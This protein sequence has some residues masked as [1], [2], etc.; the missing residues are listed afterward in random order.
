MRTAALLDLVLTLVVLVGCARPRPAAPPAATALPPDLSDLAKQ[1]PAAAPGGPRSENAGPPAPLSA[2]GE[3]V[4]PLRS[5]VAP[6][7]PGRVATV[8]VREGD[9]VKAGQPLAAFET[10]YLRLDLRRAEAELAR[11]EAVAGDAARD[12]ERKRQLVAGQSI[13]RAA[14]DHVQAA[15]DAAVAARAAAEAVVATVRQRIEDAT[16]RAPFEGVVEAKA[17]EAG[18]HVADG[19]CA[20][21]LVATARLRLRF[22]LPEQYLGRLREG[23]RVTATTDAAGSFTGRISMIG[24][25]VDPATR[26]L[27][28]EAD[29]D[30]AGG[31][32]KPGL[33]ARVAIAL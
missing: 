3:L 25:V 32:L 11:A 22:R 13:S 17:I 5:R 33:F 21:V 16:L 4:S 18:E 19:Q 26:T 24:G 31:R 27:V 23:Q 6:K 10:D 7:Q 15:H 12:L 20:F 30:N 9:L 28:A 8:F 14:L 1:A 29:V 2:T